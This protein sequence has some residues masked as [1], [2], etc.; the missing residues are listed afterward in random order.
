MVSTYFFLLHDTNGLYSGMNKI[1]C[2]KYYGLDGVAAVLVCFGNL[3]MLVATTVRQHRIGQGS[4][5]YWNDET[6]SDGVQ[7]VSLNAT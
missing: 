3:M 1:P 4:G 5:N 7:I 6:F 2:C